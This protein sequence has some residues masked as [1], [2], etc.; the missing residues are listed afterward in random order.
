MEP[1]GDASIQKPRSFAS[2]MYRSF[3]LPDG[4][5]ESRG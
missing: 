5:Q 2:G 4:E 1:D 3:P